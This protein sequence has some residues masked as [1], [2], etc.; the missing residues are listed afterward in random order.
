MPQPMTSGYGGINPM[1][2]PAVDWL[3]ANV[4]GRPQ[5]VGV[6]PHLAGDLELLDGNGGAASIPPVSPKDAPFLPPLPPLPVK[7]GPDSADVAIARGAELGRQDAERMRAAIAAREAN[8]YDTGKGRAAAV[9]ANR[10]AQALTNP[11]GTPNASAYRDLSGS[12]G[13]GAPGRGGANGLGLTVAPVPTGPKALPDNTVNISGPRELGKALAGI[14]QDRDKL[15]QDRLQLAEDSRGRIRAPKSRE[16]LVDDW[17]SGSGPGGGP[18]TREE[19]AAALRNEGAYRAQYDPERVRLAQRL[20]ADQEARQAK[21]DQRFANWSQNEQTRAQSQQLGVP[22][23]VASGIVED[24]MRQ[25]SGAPQQTAP[26][27]SVQQPSFG[28]QARSA[29][30]FGGG[31][32]ATM[33]VARMNNQGA[34]DRAAMTNQGANDREA[35]RANT[36]TEIARLNREA[37]AARDAGNHAHA[38]RLQQMAHQHQRDLLAQTNQKPLTSGEEMSAAIAMLESDDPMVKAEGLRR[39]KQLRG[40]GQAMVTDLPPNG[41]PNPSPTTNDLGPLPDP[42]SRAMWQEAQRGFLGENVSN[43]IDK[44]FKANNLNTGTSNFGRDSLAWSHDGTRAAKQRT[45]Q[46]L[47]TSTG[48]PLEQASRLFDEWYSQQWDNSIGRMPS[49]QEINTPT[50][51]WREFVRGL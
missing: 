41:A 19:L 6:A 14:Y 51:S 34:N 17:L 15:K 36:A 5:L 29:W 44:T 11:D 31:P 38:E 22:P 23:I 33:E 8:S 18:P 13:Q 1:F 49:P 2:N 12:R 48:V 26:G 50:R 32:A 46:A 25:Q 20:H 28:Q 4:L 30:L 16:M 7:P 42:A 9:A 37:Q 35:M 24:R 10:Q 43:F 21:T 39:V 45:V 3:R 47:S 27:Y 40:G